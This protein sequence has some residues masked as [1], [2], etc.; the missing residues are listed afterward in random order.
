[1]TK[2]EWER[3]EPALSDAQKERLRSPIGPAPVTC[4]LLGDDGACTVYAVRPIACRTY[5]FYVGR[6]P[7]TA[8]APEGRAERDAG[9]HCAKVTEAVGETPVVWGNGEAIAQD[10]RA[11]GPERSLAERLRDAPH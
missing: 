9:L 2:T 7:H 10:L 8:R 5:G 4:P 3:L 6:V 11:H 1:V